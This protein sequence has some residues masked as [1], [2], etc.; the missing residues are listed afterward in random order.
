VADA[1]PGTNPVISQLVG[2]VRSQGFEFEATGR[3]TNRLNIYGGYSYTDAF[4]SRSIASV[5][6]TIFG[7]PPQQQPPPISLEGKPLASVPKHQFSVYGDYRIFTNDKSSLNFNAGLVG[8]F[9]RT[10]D[11][12]ARFT[13]PDY[14]RV[15][16]GTSYRFRRFKATLA[17][18]NLLDKRYVAGSSD[19][20]FVYQGARRTL[21]VKVSYTF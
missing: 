19:A 3:V 18:E 4:V 14:G 12:V 17:V 2:S 6:N 16:V 10:G 20:S 7:L 11:N 1:I 21:T 5:A 15:D 8:V 13:L 9:D